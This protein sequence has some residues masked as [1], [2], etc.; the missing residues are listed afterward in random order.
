MINY[1]ENEDFLTALRRRKELKEDSLDWIKNHNYIGQVILEMV[2]R[3]ASKPCFSGYTYIKD[4]KG[5]AIERCLTNL[6]N[7]NPDK[8]RNPFSYFTT[9]ITRSFL[10]YIE[11]EKRQRMMVYELQMGAAESYGTL[12]EQNKEHMKR[13]QGELQKYEEL[14]DRRRIK[15]G[16]RRIMRKEKRN[17]DN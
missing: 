2:N 16:K 7:F 12:T 10:R 6:D 4:M 15:E 9:T 1:V 14:K 11:M 13:I 5:N 17:A 3:I 8:S